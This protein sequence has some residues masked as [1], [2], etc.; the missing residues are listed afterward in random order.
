MMLR[1]DQVREGPRANER[2][3]ENPV[4]EGRSRMRRNRFLLILG[5]VAVLSTVVFYAVT[6][7]DRFQKWYRPPRADLPSEDDV[8]EMRASLLEWGV[9]LMGWPRTPEFVVPAE[10]VPVSFAD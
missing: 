8:V 2:R 6:S 5:V 10:Q 9:G 3:A 1:A 4:N 7:S